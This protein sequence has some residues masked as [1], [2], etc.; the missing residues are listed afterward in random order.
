MISINYYLKDI[1][2]EKNI[3]ELLKADKTETNKLL[4]KSRHILMLI[5]QPGNRKKIYTNRKAS[6]RQWNKNKQEINCRKMPIG[7]DEINEFLI[8]FKKRSYP[9]LPKG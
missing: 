6:I 8:N 4:D 2:G 9:I 7:G 1:P 3:Q 5:N